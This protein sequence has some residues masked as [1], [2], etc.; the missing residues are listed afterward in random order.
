[1]MYPAIRGCTGVTTTEERSNMWT[2]MVF[3][4]WLGHF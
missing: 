1:M 2:N 3:S 4:A